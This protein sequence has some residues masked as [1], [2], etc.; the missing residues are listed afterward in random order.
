MAETTYEK[1]GLIDG[2]GNLYLIKQ[3]DKGTGAKAPTYDSEVFET[4]SIEQVEVSLTINSKDVFLSNVI[5]GSNENVTKA[6]ITLQAGYFPAGFAEEAQGMVKEGEGLWSM[7]TN[8]KKKPFQMAFPIT[9]S[10]DNEIIMIFS[11]CTLGATNT[12]AQTRKEDR[13]EQIPSYTITATP[14]EYRP[15]D[16]DVSKVYYLADLTT[17]EAKKAWDRNKLLTTPIYDS[18]S[19]ATAKATTSATPV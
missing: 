9:D 15:S 4:P 2:V 1:R 19:L 16:S 13:T 3:T 7:P 17:K 14:V 8:P 18:K 5:H 12:S 11:N 6:E 10:D